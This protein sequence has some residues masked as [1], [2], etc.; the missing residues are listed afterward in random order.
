MKSSIWQRTATALALAAALWVSACA[1]CNPPPDPDGD[2]WGATDLPLD[3]WRSD[4]I[5]CAENDCRDYRVLRPAGPGVVTVELVA[6]AGPGDVSLSVADSG[7]APVETVTASVGGRAAIRF[8]PRHERYYVV[9]LNASEL[10]RD[11][12]PYEIRARQEQPPQAPPPPAFEPVSARILEVENP[13][14]G[15]RKVLIDLGESRGMTPGL[16][17][18]LIEDGSPIGE[19]EIIEVFPDGSRARLEGTSSVRITPKTSA[20]IDV[21]VGSAGP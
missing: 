14:G 15:E 6:Q 2:P 21:P 10:A 13:P 4:Q 18:R 3:V 8:E 17:G 1:S 20:E 11:A 16:R 9:V 5:W 19:I 12:Y 7:N